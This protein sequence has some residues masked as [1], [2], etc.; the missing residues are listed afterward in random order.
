[1]QSI[2]A[3]YNFKAIF[4]LTA[5]GTQRFEGHL[6]REWVGGCN[7]DSASGLSVEWKDKSYFRLDI[8]SKF[9]NSV[10]LGNKMTGHIANVI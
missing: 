4:F 3:E 9:T 6:L 10:K 7:C 8:I 2:I 1:M 5:G